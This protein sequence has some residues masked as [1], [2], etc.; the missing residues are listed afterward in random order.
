V[1]TDLH[2]VR[3]RARR[4]LE[5]GRVRHAALAVGLLLP[6]L[7]L[8]VV[9]APR[10]GWAAAWS[11][12]A[13]LVAFVALWR[14]QAWARGVLPGFVCALLPLAS[15]HAAARIG[16]L[17]TG[18]GCVSLCA[19]LCASGGVLA[20]LAL[21]RWMRRQPSAWSAYAVSA[22]LVVAVGATG[23]TCLGL[24]GVLGVLGGVLFG[25]VALALGRSPAPTRGS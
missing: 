18:D 14:G 6:V 10:A 22:A 1:A 7:A 5:R 13:A 19:P 12:G 8:V 20:G 21:A 24:G 3:E 4:A 23:C 11:A 2:I 16:H 9:V 17:C 25:G 15:A